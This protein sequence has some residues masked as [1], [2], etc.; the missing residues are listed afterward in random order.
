[1]NT[2]AKVAYNT[3]IQIISKVISTILMLFAIAI[4]TR[5]LGQ[6]GFGQ[7]TIIITFLSFFGVLADLGLTLVTTQLI[8]QPNNDEKTFINNLF[9][10]RFFSA[11]FFLGLAPLVVFFMPYE[12]IVKLGIAIITLS[13][14]FIALNQIMVGLFQKHL[15]MIAVAV[16]EIISKIILLVGM[17]VI[18]YL[19]KG[20]TGIMIISVL[21]SAVS[22]FVHFG[23]AQKIVKI[24]FRF[25]FPLW[26]EIIKK[27]WP[28]T[29]TIVFNLIYLRA[30]TL[31]LSLIKDPSEVGIYG[32]SYRIVDFLTTL[33]FMFCGVI[34]PLLTISWA[35]SQIDKFKKI[36][37]KSF[38][39]IIIITIPMLI[40]T[41]LVS[42][43]I[44][45]LIAG[46]E[47]I[48]SGEVLK[49][50]ILATS[51]V[52]F[53]CLFSH[54]VIALD[55]QKKM[56]PFYLL[57][58][59]TSVA[60]YLYFIPKYSYFGAAWVTVYSELL[61]A[62]ASFVLVVKISGLRLKL[63]IFLKTLIASL[64]MAVVVY[65][66]RTNLNIILT[67]ILAISTYLI[68][69]YLLKGITKNDFLNLINKPE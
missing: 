30:D 3:T 25:D 9:T 59:V 24:K 22:F 45:S 27:S 48:A 28:L 21:A 37:Q 26:L 56:I 19:N 65:F 60:G 16:A 7:Y 29:L 6:S 51:A 52:F 10:L 35:N 40:G 64:L 53:G 50:L 4:M 8:S 11:L 12:P 66:I 42:K 43:Q 31:I 32:A 38:D 15:K 1:M 13:F 33:P 47:F 68:T 41:Q 57:T 5:Y 39:A 44:I 2:S 62:L 23:Y 54:A 18:V 34:L 63:N 20:L 67:L 14:F 36:M 17:I 58:A 46:T 69:L 55:K 61:I 49:I